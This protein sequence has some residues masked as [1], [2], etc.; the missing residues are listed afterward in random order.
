M[1]QLLLVAAQNGHTEVVKLLLKNGAKVDQEMMSGITPYAQVFYNKLYATDENLKNKYQEVLK[2]LQENGADTK[3]RTSAVL[4]LMLKLGY[5]INELG[6]C[7]GIARM[8]IEATLKEDWNRFNK[9]MDKI[10]KREFFELAKS[11]IKKKRM[12][13]KKA[14]NSKASCNSK[15]T[16]DE[17]ELRAFLDG[18]SLYYAGSHHISDYSSGGTQKSG[19]EIINS[20]TQFL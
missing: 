12:C 16:A 15:L 19:R 8:G 18:I 11:I 7:Y 20:S 5:P 1:E 13:R 9:R 6:H 14:H 17:V 2:L 3:R 10:Q 4:G